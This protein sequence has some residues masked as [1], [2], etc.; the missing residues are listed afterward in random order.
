MNDETPPHMGAV[1][2]DSIDAHCYSD[3]PD[4]SDNEDEIFGFSTSEPQLMATMNRL[5]DLKIFQK[6]KTPLEIKW[7]H[8]LETSSRKRLSSDVSSSFTSDTFIS[9][10]KRRR[11]RPS[12]IK[13]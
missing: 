8:L 4:V 12:K 10:P 2:S 5:M 6:Y 11:G 7:N 3:V 1:Q 9:V 13:V